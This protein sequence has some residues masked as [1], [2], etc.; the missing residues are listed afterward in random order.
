MVLLSTCT[1]SKNLSEG[2]LGASLVWFAELCTAK[3]CKCSFLTGNIGTRIWHAALSI[4]LWASIFLQ[5]VIGLGRNPLQ[6]IDIFMKGSDNYCTES[7]SHGS[8]LAVHRSVHE[9]CV[10]KIEKALPKRLQ[11]SRFSLDILDLEKSAQRTSLQ[12]IQLDHRTPFQN[13]TQAK[14]WGRFQ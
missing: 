3:V 2:S 14:C 9:R 8:E 4:A 1:K 7:S 11:G 12:T 13:H 10:R 6:E 5:I